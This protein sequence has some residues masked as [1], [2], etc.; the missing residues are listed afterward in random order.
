MNRKKNHSSSFDLDLF[1][2]VSFFKV[3]LASAGGLVPDKI[4]FDSSHHDFRKR[5]NNIENKYEFEY[6]LNPELDKI[7]QSKFISQGIDEKSFNRESYLRD[8]V[9]YAKKGIFSFDRTNISN[10]SDL[11]FHLVAYPV[12]D[13]SYKEY[14][15]QFLNKYSLRNKKN[16]TPWRKILQKI[17]NITDLLD[18]EK[19]I[20]NDF[21]YFEFDS[22][23]NEIK[24]PNNYFFLEGQVNKSTFFLEDY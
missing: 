6:R 9:H 5:I 17:W 16:F 12:I 7:I 21:S 24:D 8:F 13:D 15:F 2:S 1:F 11:R 3:H 10:P 22:F 14:F 19:L 4:F 18:Y 20:I 23:K